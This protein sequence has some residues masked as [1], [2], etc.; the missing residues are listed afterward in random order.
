MAAA[1]NEIE[2]DRGEGEA[3]SPRIAESPLP[4][5]EVMMRGRIEDGEDGGSELRSGA[6]SAARIRLKTGVGPNA[7]I[8]V[9]ST[10]GDGG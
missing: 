1:C 9:C 3:D 7:R 10:V 6:M 8:D 5:E 2:A 4:F